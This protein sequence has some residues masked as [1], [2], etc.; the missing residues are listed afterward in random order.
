ML[1]GIITSILLVL[2]LAGWA[3]AWNPRRKA[4]FDAA[5]QLALDEDSNEE[6]P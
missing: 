4:E 5:A 1:S 2:F 6:Q 3:W